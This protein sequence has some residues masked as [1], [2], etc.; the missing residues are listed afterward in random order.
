MTN[1]VE[2]LTHYVDVAKDLVALGLVV[3]ELTGNQNLKVLFGAATIA[4]AIVKMWQ[5][6]QEYTRHKA[7]E[8]KKTH[9]GRKGTDMAT[10]VDFVEAQRRNN[11][12]KFAQRRAHRARAA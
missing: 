12:L 5:K 1:T 11:I 9:T 6:R 7:K 10:A 3:G 8:N 2:K 4:N